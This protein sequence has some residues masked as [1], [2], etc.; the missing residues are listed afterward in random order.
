MLFIGFLIVF[1]GL[2]NLFFLV[3]L[4]K[5]FSGTTYFPFN[6]SKFQDPP[7][8]VPTQ[9]DN[10]RYESNH[11]VNWNF[12]CILIKMA[13]HALYSRKNVSLFKFK[14][15]SWIFSIFLICL[16]LVQRLKCH[17]STCYLYLQKIIS[18]LGDWPYYFSY[19]WRGCVH[20]QAI[21][22]HPVYLCL[23]T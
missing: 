7:E 14:S 11:W 20:P 10:P 5:L 4:Y 18:M 12:T 16:S 1:Y 17:I 2:Q 6:F 21:D 9:Q 19:Y 13:L 15:T 22:G 3:W 23:T 8:N